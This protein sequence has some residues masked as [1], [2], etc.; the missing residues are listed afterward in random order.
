MNFHEIVQVSVRDFEKK[1]NWRIEPKS[2][3][4]K[5]SILN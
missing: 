1:K 2:A 5:K 4:F 3:L